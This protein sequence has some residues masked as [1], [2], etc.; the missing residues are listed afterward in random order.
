M[1]NFIEKYSKK[2]AGNEEK[3]DKFDDVIDFK[4]VRFEEVN[5]R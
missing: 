2:D 3:D 1:K 4:E 5:N